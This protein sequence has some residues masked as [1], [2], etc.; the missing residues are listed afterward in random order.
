MLSPSE[1]NINILKITGSKLSIAE[2]YRERNEIELIMREYEVVLNLVYLLSDICM[3]TSFSTNW[4]I[5]KLEIKLLNIILVYSIRYIKKMRYKC[6]M[7]Y[8]TILRNTWNVV[9]QSYLGELVS[10]S[11]T[12]DI[13]SLNG[14]I[15]NSKYVLGHESGYGF[16]V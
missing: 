11:G 7:H 2:C 8:E 3:R 16:G 14:L 9:P 1:L 15:A 12:L 5:L 13:N 6:Y 10:K 4:K